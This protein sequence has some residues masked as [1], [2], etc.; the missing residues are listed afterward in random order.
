MF[1]QSTIAGAIYTLRRCHANCCCGRRANLMR[2]NCATHPKFTRVAACTDDQPGAGHER[3][4]L[5]NYQK[6]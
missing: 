1:G 3:R 6:R 4:V 2:A 5:V